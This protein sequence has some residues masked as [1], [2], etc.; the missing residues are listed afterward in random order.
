MKQVFRTVVDFDGHNRMTRLI[1]ASGG[2]NVASHVT[3]PSGCLH[4][5]G[6]VCDKSI[7]H[8]NQ[9]S[10]ALLSELSSCGFGHVFNR[11]CNGSHFILN[12]K[13]S[14]LNNID[15]TVLPPRGTAG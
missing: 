5:N 13:I 11:V 1:T 2:S 4:W 3:K 8:S 14:G 12:F 15:N 6:Q 7:P 9:N 10:A